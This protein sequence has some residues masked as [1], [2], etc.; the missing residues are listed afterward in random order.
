[1]IKAKIRSNKI[2]KDSSPSQEDENDLVK[3]ENEE[4]VIQVRQSQLK[5]EDK[6]DVIPLNQRTEIDST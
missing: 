5:Q 6:L 1:M 2:F 3:S 4:D